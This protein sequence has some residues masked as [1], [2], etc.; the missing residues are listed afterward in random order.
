MKK[1][2][3]LLIFLS[4]FISSHAFG[5][6]LTGT[7]YLEDGLVGVLDPENNG[8][9]IGDEMTGRDTD[10]NSE[11]WNEYYWRFDGLTRTEDIF[12]ALIDNGDGTASRN[13]EVIREDGTFIL[14]GDNLWGQPTGTTYEVSIDSHFTGVNNYA[15]NGTGWEWVNTSGSNH[16]WGNFVNAPYLFELTDNVL[17]DY[18][19]YNDIVRHNVF[20]GTMTNVVMS[21]APVPEPATMLLFGTGLVGLVGSRFRRKKK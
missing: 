6:P 12:G 20:R 4:L 13:I 2:T 3:I 17:L 10:I 21:V 19:G 5:L 1:I 7:W 14:H 16:F 9:E 18:Y 15:W 8:G 11:P